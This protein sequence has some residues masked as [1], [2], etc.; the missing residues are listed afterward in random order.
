MEKIL[1][2]H[3]RYSYAEKALFHND[4]DPQADWRHEYNKLKARSQILQNNQRSNLLVHLMGEQLDTLSIKELQNLE[5]Q[6]ECSLKHIR[7]RKE[8]LLQEQNKTM[9]KEI[10][11]KEKALA[12]AQN[13]VLEQQKHSTQHFLIS[14]SSPYPTTRYYQQMPDKETSPQ[15]Q[16]SLGSSLL[17]PWMLN[18]LN[19]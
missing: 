5:Q 6:L 10:K 12:S 13:P 8:K 17:P 4:S 2:K 3:E 14:G 9:E 11:A 1:E 19:G 15:A 16:L 7:S 18:R